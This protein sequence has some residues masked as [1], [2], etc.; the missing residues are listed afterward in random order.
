[1]ADEV[2]DMEITISGGTSAAA[3]MAGLSKAVSD[4]TGQP[5]NLSVAGVGSMRDAAAAVNSTA[6]AADRAS[7]HPPRT[8]PV[9]S[10]GRGS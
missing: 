8:R 4:L 3:V 5:V 9:I 7:P 2:Y 6:S 1:M 10:G